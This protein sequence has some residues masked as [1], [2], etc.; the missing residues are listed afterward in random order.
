MILEDES[1]A[2][3]YEHVIFETSIRE[4]ASLFGRSGSGAFKIINLYQKQKNKVNINH[5]ER[6]I[7]IR[8]SKTRSAP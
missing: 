2:M 1:I 7:Q 8:E 6:L 5:F 3:I 4:V